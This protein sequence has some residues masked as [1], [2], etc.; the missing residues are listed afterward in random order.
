[1][2]VFRFITEGTVEEKIIERADR[3]LFLDA[4]VI[5]QGRLAEQ[6][7]SLEKG[8]LMKMVRFGADQIL[9]GKGGTYTDE[10]I[11]ALIAKGEEKTSEMQAKLETDAKHN[12]ANFSLMADE[13]EGT[14]TFSFGGKNYR[15]ADK[16]STAGI[17]INLPQRQRKRNYDLNA[18]ENSGIQ[19]KH[20]TDAKTKVKKR[21]GPALYDFQLFDMERLNEILKKERAMAARKEAELKSI[22]Q[23]REEAMHAP[24]FGSGVAPGR[25]KEELLQLAERKENDL[26]LFALSPEE[27]V[28]KE[29]IYA[30]GFPDWSRKDF[31]A[32]CSALVGV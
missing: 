12:L 9:S 8:E 31:K 19:G 15:D 21:K 25:S 26:F 1:M 2:Q 16:G 5:Q 14:D 24:T 17:F 3:K 4:A 10:D 32:F 22:A 7:S 29:Q 6:N 30:E 27:T 11:D 13:E 20:K 23:L 18:M 28:E